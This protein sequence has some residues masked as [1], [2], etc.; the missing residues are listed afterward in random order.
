M[1][2]LPQHHKRTFQERSVEEHLDRYNL[3]RELEYQRND[4]RHVSHLHVA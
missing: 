4:N 1:E 2:Y 3:Y